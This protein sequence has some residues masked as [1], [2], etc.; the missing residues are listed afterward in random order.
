MTSKASR[1]FGSQEKMVESA[2]ARLYDIKR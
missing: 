2:F 1:K